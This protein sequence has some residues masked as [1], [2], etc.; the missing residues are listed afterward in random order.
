[1]KICQRI[2]VLYRRIL[3]SG[4]LKSVLTLSSGVVV[5]QGI[6][7][8]GMPLVGRVYSPAAMGDYTIITASAG[9]IMSVACLGMMTAFMLPEKDEETRGL[10]RLV[11]FSTLG[12]TTLAILALWLCSGFYR[13]FHTE[14]TPY[15]LS[16]L[17]LWL[18]IV[19]YTVSNICYAYVNRQKLYRVM[20]WNPIIAAGINVCCGI[21]FG[22]LGW[23]FLGY[24]TA[25][26]L[27]FAVNII[28]LICHANPYER[29]SDPAFRCLPLLKGYRRFP[30]YQMPANLI[31]SVGQQIPVQMMEVLYSSTALGLYSMAQRILS[32]PS[33]LLSAPINRVYYQEASARYN[34]REDIGYFSFEILQA[35]IKLAMIPILLLTLFGEWIFAVFLGQ[36]WRRAGTFAAVL[37]CHQLMLFCRQCL[38]GAPTIIGQNRINLYDALTTLALNGLLCLIA[39]LYVENPLI[40]LAFLSTADIFRILVFQGLFLKLTG[41]RVSIYLKFIFRWVFLPV[42]LAWG[43]RLAVSV[44]LV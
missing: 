6:N 9:V 30:I 13:I 44:L 35:N 23:G 1:M 15:A 31:D 36:Q 20:F 34:R 8:L 4:F 43:M 17:V 16:L 22:L 10:S 19:F 24:T 39:W 42:G 2:Q 3:S 33:L 32:I 7:F 21:L 14:E 37:G 40:F 41:F 26:I 11:T 5:A 38:S 29:I 27:S 28:H 25:H 12:I 18:Y